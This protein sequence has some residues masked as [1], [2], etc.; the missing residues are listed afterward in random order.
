MKVKVDDPLAPSLPEQA[1][2]GPVPPAL[3]V[4]AVIHRLRAPRRSSSTAGTDTVS[5]TPAQAA[6]APVVVLQGEPLALCPLA[7]P[8]FRET[9]CGY[10]H[11]QMLWRQGV[12]ELYGKIVQLKMVLLENICF[13][14]AEIARSQRLRIRRLRGPICRGFWHDDEP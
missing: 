13:W 11:G 3:P 5:T 14:Q 4:Q 8:H 1:V 2:R 9:C 7:L 6:G 12:N 10:W